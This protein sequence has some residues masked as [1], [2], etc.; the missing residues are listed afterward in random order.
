MGEWFLHSYTNSEGQWVSERIFT[1][2]EAREEL[3]MIR[4]GDLEESDLWM[5]FDRYSNLT[6]AQQT[7]L[8]TYRQALRDIP[9]CSDPFNPPYPTKPSWM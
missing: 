5:L 9:A 2:D 8:T 4:N 7:E 3:R 6:E 1:E